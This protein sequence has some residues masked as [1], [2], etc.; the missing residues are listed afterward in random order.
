MT[1]EPVLQPIHEV[2]PPLL[3]RQIVR[4]GLTLALGA[5]CI[6]FAEGPAVSALV[7]SDW[8][9]AGGVVGVVLLLGLNLVLR[10]A[11]RRL[12][13]AP[14]RILDERQ[15]EIRN[16]AYRLSH[17][18]LAVAFGVPLWLLFLRGTAAVPTWLQDALSNGGLIVVYL[19]I[20]FFTPTAVIAWIEPDAPEDEELEPHRPS[21]VERISWGV[22]VAIIL[23]PFAL[24]VALPFTG[25]TTRQTHLAP[26]TSRSATSPRATCRYVQ[27]TAS[28]GIGVSASI[29]LVGEYCSNGKRIHRLWGLFHWDCHPAMTTF[30]TVSMHCAT[31][32]DRRGTMHLRYQAVVKASLLPIVQRQIA[33][34]LVV[35]HDGHILRFP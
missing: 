26:F 30:T 21:W 25:S 3:G 4:R 20:L 16:Y 18:V 9:T 12:A 13:I 8:A 6:L 33:L 31:R 19:E 17:R 1:A 28:A 2:P 24:S 5:I 23:L 32:F 10:S 29:P 34:N 14:D 27:A 15:R 35:R 22:I 7:G 11:T